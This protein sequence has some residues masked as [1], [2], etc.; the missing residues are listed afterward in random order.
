MKVEPAVHP[1]NAAA[2]SEGLRI[3]K[4]LSFPRPWSGHSAEENTDIKSSLIA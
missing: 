1:F 3:E 2:K 4:N